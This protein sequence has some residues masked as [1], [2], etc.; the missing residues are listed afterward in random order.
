[1][2][3]KSRIR[4]RK[5]SAYLE[6]NPGLDREPGLSNI[7]RS[8]FDSSPLP[9]ATLAGTDHILYYVNPAF[10]RLAGKTKDELTGKPFAAVLTQDRCLASLNRVYGTGEAGVHAEPEDPDAHSTSWAYTMWP[11]RGAG[12]RPVGVMMQ[13][14]ETTRFHQRAIAMNEQLLVSRVRQ[15]ELGE[16][17]ERLN[18]QLQLEIADWKRM[19]RA[20]VNSEK[21]AVTARFALTMAHEINNPLEAITN[22]I[23]LLAPL[24]T[25]SEAQSY[26]AT[27]E[28]QLQGLSR[29]ATHMLKFHRDSNRA[30][31]FKLSAVLSEILDFYR[32]QAEQ[33]G[34]ILHQRIET[35]GGIVAFRSEIVQVITN[36][37]LNALDATPASGQVVAH[38]YPAPSWLRE[39][40]ARYGYCLS[41]ADTGTGVAPQDRARIFQPFFTT[42]GERGTGLGLWVSAGIIDRIGGSIRV[43]SNVPA[44]S[45][46]HMFLNLPV[47]RSSHLHT[48]SPP[49]QRVEPFRRHHLR[50]FLLPMR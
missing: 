4:H 33:R 37:L 18:A 28:D 17:A 25:S 44:G 45:F 43:W 21:L 41:I 5:T 36:L 34:I 39:I 1:M 38:L 40:H 32:P 35:D 12:D 48:A 2:I 23:F 14:T 49:S 6:A 19:E 3:R 31:E 42:K 7:E 46:G 27:I 20:L 29:I 11:I 50:F 47:R 22:L 10:C 24:Q 16:M 13:V 8:I 9:T 26:V 15:H 30:A